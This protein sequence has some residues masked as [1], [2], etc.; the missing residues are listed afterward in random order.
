MQAY[1]YGRNASLCHPTDSKPLDREN[2]L[3]LEQLR[4]MALEWANS[5]D[6]EIHRIQEQTC[7]KLKSQSL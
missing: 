5:I 1:Y 2:I 7:R 6:T 4:L 3:Y